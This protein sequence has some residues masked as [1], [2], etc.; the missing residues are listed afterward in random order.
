MER[1][2]S[3]VELL[4]F[5]DGG[6]DEAAAGHL[7]DCATCRE[8]LA[9]QSEVDAALAPPVP[10]PLRAELRAA[11][12]RALGGAPRRRWLVPALAAA[13]LLVASALLWRGDDA[14]VAVVHRER[15]SATLRGVEERLHLQVTVPVAGWLAVFARN[16]GDSVQRLLPHA[17]PTLGWLGVEQPV[18]AGKPVRVPGA[19]LFDFAIE[20]AAPPRELVLVLGEAAFADAELLRIAKE[21]QAA[22]VGEIAAAVR[23]RYKH[24][25]LAAV[26][27]R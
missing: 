19:E 25:L 7:R 12:V 24:S 8:R 27:V 9:E 23:S 4:A 17:D 26:P 14:M 21:L 13:A 15:G 16:A 6:E 1:H 3:N 5:A 22:P 18:P 11:T 20:P 2:L 10:P